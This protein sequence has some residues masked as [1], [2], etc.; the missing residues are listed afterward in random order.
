MISPRLAVAGALVAA[1]TVLTGVLGQA[2]TATAQ[3]DPSPS[4]QP[5][6]AASPTVPGP[7]AAPFDPQPDAGTVEAGKTVSVMVLKNDGGDPTA[8]KGESTTDSRATVSVD[9][10]SINFT[11]PSPHRRP[12]SF[13]YT[14]TD[15]QTQASTTVT[16]NVTAPPAPP[17]IRRVSISMPRTVVALHVYTISGTVN[18]AAPG[19]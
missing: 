14:A 8:T 5:E 15:G 1:V 19:P 11:A 3:D 18:L 17:A 16:V 6:A 7:T 12:A 4:P 9:Q 13:G 2:G 10:K